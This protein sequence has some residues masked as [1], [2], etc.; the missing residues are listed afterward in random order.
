M[1]KLI[2]KIQVT[3]LALIHTNSAIIASHMHFKYKI[4]YKFNIVWNN[5][6]VQ[7]QFTTISTVAQDIIASVN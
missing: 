1:G 2:C 6:S 7:A 3:Q 5:S 4:Q